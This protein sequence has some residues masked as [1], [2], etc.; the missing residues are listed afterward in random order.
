MFKK[1]WTLIII[2]FTCFLTSCNYN[3]TTFGVFKIGNYIPNTLIGV[4]VN[5]KPYDIHNVSVKLY[6]GF[7]D[8]ETQYDLTYCIYVENSQEDYEEISWVYDYKKLKNHDFITS[9][10][11]KEALDSFKY[12]IDKQKVIYENYY[13]LKLDRSL[14]KYKSGSIIIKVIGFVKTTENTYKLCDQKVNQVINISY[15]VNWKNVYLA[16]L[17]TAL[18]QFE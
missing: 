8:I 17:S 5:K 6:L 2:S 9:F 10:T 14:F 1:L 18:A 13:D 11:E 7:T 12:S 16:E 4:E 15:S 3:S